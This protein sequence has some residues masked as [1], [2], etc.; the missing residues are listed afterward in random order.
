MFREIGAVK[1]FDEEYSG[2]NKW[3][4]IGRNKEDEIKQREKHP[5]RQYLSTVRIYGDNDKYQY[6]I[7]AMKTYNK[8][9]EFF[10]LIFSLQNL[11]TFKLIVF[12][13]STTKLKRK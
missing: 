12:K 3:F 2:K 11:K 6:R 9:W 1:E 8:V 7:T 10:I 4:H 5:H 13:F